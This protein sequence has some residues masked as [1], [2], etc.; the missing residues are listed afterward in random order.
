NEIEQLFLQ[1][2]IFRADDLKVFYR[3]IKISNSNCPCKILISI[4][5]KQQPLAVHRNKIKRLIR[6][7]WRKNNAELKQ[8]L[9]QNNS[10]LHVAFICFASK[11]PTY[12]EIESKIIITLHHLN[13]H[14]V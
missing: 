5:K 12:K 13:K 8:T 14:I 3:F 1:G 10:T 6:E 4:P 9:I 7:V 2:K 11:I